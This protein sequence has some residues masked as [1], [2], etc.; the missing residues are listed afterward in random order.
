LLFVFYQINIPLLFA[1]EPPT[2]ENINELVAKSS[3]NDFSLNTY[4]KDQLGFSNG[5]DEEIK[6]EGTT[7]K[8]YKWICE[9]GTKEDVPHWY[10]LYLRSVNHFHNPLD[11]IANA[12]FHGIFFGTFLCGESSILWS[13]EQTG[14]QY[15]G[16]YYSW[17][18]V[19]DY[20]YKAL[21]ATDKTSQ[22]LIL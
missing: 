6:N 3:L 22:K 8:V 18:D 11:D 1:L 10:E 14:R 21:N 15:P 2:H 5:Y 9:G 12:G 7:K 20:F 16:G 4:L 13:Q 17:H 19:R